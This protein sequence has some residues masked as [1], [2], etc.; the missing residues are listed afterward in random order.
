VVQ[1]TQTY[2]C[3]NGHIRTD[4]YDP[5]AAP[6]NGR[7]LTCGEAL[8]GHCPRCN[9]RVP[10]K[11]M[12]AGVSLAN[13]SLFD[14][15]PQCGE[16]YPWAAHASHSSGGNDAVS[17]IEQICQRFQLVARRLQQRHA[18]RGTLVVA[19]EY[20]VQ[21]LLAAVLAADFDD[22]RNEE[23]SPS[24]AGQNSRIDFVLVGPGIAVETKMTRES[25]TDEKLAEELLVDIRR[26]EEHP[27]ARH[28]VCFVYDPELR[29]KNP[30]GLVRDLEKTA[31]RFEMLKVIIAPRGT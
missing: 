2:V 19:D 13:W 14:R 20:D 26:Y 15:C 27:E 7:C 9:A 21:D 22:V 1:E 12:A 24:V 28:L 6:P 16:A 17:R 31:T 8:L 29:L 4:Q 30:A 23:F 3:R 10:G 25:L 11:P 18:K 5:N